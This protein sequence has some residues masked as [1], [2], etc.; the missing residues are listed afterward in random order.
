MSRQYLEL[1]TASTMRPSARSLSAIIELGVGA[2]SG[3]TVDAVTAACGRRPAGWFGQDQNEST[4]TP[5]LVVLS[6]TPIRAQD[7]AGTWQ[8]TLQAGPRSLRILF[9]V[10]AA[11]G[12]ALRGVL[13]RLFD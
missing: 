11:D 10:S 2:E 6:V 12:G 8:G 5:A 3:Q 4:R 7:L 13:R 1:D 9:V